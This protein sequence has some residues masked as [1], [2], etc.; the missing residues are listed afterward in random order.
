MRLP[1]KQLQSLN[2]CAW[3][4]ASSFE[5]ANSWGSSETSLP[6]ILCIW[7]HHET[8]EEN[9]LDYSVDRGDARYRVARR[10]HIRNGGLSSACL[11]SRDTLIPSRAALFFNT[12]RIASPCSSVGVFL[13]ANLSVTI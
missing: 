10:L 9:S 3:L 8:P 5:A 1:R 2:E 6:K 12:S 4:L 7:S 11:L 13:P